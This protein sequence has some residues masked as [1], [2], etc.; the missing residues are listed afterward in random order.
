VEDSPDGG[1]AIQPQGPTSATLMTSAMP[2]AFTAFTTSALLTAALSLNVL[3]L[4]F[5]APFVVKAGTEL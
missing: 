5:M 2:L 1:L 4:L 3:L